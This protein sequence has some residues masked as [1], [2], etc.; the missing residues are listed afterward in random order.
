MEV[1]YKVF[2][3]VSTITFF[4]NITTNPVKQRNFKDFQ[5]K[6]FNKRNTFI[7][8]K[9]YLRKITPTTKLSSPHSLTIHIQLATVNTRTQKAVGQKV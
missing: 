7:Y 9:N 5:L 2:T 4:Q 1:T 6:F 3:D 8:D